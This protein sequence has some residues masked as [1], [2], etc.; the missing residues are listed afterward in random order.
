MRVRLVSL[1]G[2]VAAVPALASSSSKDPTWW[3]KY[4]FIQ[5]GTD[6][7]AVGTTGSATV[8][9][10]VNVSNE[11]GPQSETFITML[12]TQIIAA[13]SNEIFRLPMRGYSSFDGGN[14]WTG[15]D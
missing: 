14:T 5:A 4:Q 9:S 10:N 15:T 7:G 12:N 8:G 13:G 6:T 11:C 1:I 3:Q 2:L